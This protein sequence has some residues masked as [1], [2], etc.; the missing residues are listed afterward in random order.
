MSAEK[1]A[2]SVGEFTDRKTI[3]RRS[4]AAAFGAALVFLGI[5]STPAYAVAGCHLCDAPG[6]CGTLYCAWC[7]WGDCVSHTR[8]LCC[9]GYSRGSSCGGGCGDHQKCSYVGGTKS[10]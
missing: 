5:R 10:C 6:G 3:L 8:H 9:E 2:L 4:G 1:F 7:W